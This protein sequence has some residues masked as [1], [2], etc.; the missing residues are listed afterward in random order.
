[1]LARKSQPEKKKPEQ[2]QNIK[3]AA[4]VCIDGVGI[5]SRFQQQLDQLELASFFFVRLAYF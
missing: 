4:M 5:R 2:S 3:R 1:L